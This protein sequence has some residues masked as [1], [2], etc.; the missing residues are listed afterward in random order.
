M[1]AENNGHQ[2]CVKL[3]REVD[4]NVVLIAKLRAELAAKTQENDVLHLM[5]DL[6]LLAVFV[7]AVVINY[8]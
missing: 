3:L 2:D 1:L 5:M 7:L 6:N 4:P 8:Y